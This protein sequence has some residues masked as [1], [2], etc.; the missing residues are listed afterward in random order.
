M[1]YTPKF[2]HEGLPEWKRKKDPV[3]SKLFYRPVSFV[4]SSLFSSVG[5]TAN[6]VSYLSAVVAIMACAFFV[7][8]A[9][10]AGAILINVWLLLDCADGNI[11]RCVKKEKYGDFADSMSSYVCGGFM[12]ACM[13]YSVCMTGGIIFQQGDSRI[14]L[15]GAI[16]GSCDSLMRLLYQ[17]FKN[18]SY[19][20]GID[21]YTSEDPER[22]SGLNRLRMK[23]DATVSLGGF[24]PSA[25]LLGAIFGALDL[26]VCIWAAYYAVTFLATSVYLVRETYRSNMRIEEES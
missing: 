3:L 9:P 15:I 22:E 5:W 11:A 10:I 25:V 2:F 6:S 21:A 17:K 12:F 19:L 24:L 4:L 23:V 13:G 14:V 7:S 20:I 1:K 8:G 16:A 26:V 18:S